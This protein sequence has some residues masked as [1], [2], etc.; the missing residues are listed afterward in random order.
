MKTYTV[1]APVRLST[2][3]IQLTDEQ[4]AA[5]SHGLQKTPAP[6]L[7]SIEKTIEFKVGERFAYNGVIPKSMAEAMVVDEANT[8]APLQ[9]K[10]K[11]QRARKGKA[12]K[13]NQEG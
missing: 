8:V 10:E 3:L 2:G 12:E 9:S 1:I 4:A 7:Y 13:T 5:R 6:G 11:A